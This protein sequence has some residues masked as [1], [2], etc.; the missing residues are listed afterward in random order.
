MWQW[1]KCNISFSH[2]K[3]DRAESVDFKVDV[4]NALFELLKRRANDSDTSREFDST[5]LGAEA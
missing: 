4:D 2:D 3:D 1:Y 5:L